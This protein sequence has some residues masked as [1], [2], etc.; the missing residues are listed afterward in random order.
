MYSIDSNDDVKKLHLHT[1]CILRSFKKQNGDLYVVE[2]LHA[3][4][5]TR[6]KLKRYI[7]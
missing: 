3:Q 2:F 5:S 4:E 1:S 6:L 7:K